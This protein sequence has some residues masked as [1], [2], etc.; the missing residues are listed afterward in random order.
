M[1]VFRL[2]RGSLLPDYGDEEEKESK[3]G[4][5]TKRTQEEVE[6]LMNTKWRERINL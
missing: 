6:Q 2:P 1:D 4:I 3:F 5:G